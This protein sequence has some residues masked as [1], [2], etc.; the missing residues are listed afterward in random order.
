MA[1]IGKVIPGINKFKTG[2]DD[3]DSWSD[4][5]FEEAEEGEELPDPQSRSGCQ[6]A[7]TFCS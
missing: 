3:Y 6:A 7:L 1:E 5:E 2:S 4:D